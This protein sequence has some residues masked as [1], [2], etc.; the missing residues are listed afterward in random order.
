MQTSEAKTV[1]NRSSLRV[2]NVTK[3]QFIGKMQRE[4]SETHAGTR[5]SVEKRKCILC[6]LEFG[7][8]GIGVSPLRSCNIGA[9]TSMKDGVGYRDTIYHL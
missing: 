8:K 3:N 9:K 2:R 6:L 5:L 7:A 4:V 1:L